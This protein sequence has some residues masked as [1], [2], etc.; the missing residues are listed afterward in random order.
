MEEQDLIAR[1]FYAS[2]T[3][4]QVVGDNIGVDKSTVSDMVNGVLIALASLVNQFVSFPK[5]EQ[6]AQTEHRFFLLGNMPDTIRVIDC[7]HV[8]APNER[9]STE[10]GGTASTSHLWERLSSS[11][12]TVL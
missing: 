6:I 11:S 7:T 1:R 12:Q 3:F 5:D 8:Q 10:K 9:E 2:K 4:Y